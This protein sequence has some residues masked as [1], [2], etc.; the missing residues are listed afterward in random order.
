MDVTR[1]FD[2]TPSRVVVA[3]FYSNSCDNV[4]TL[5]RRLLIQAGGLTSDITH[6]PY[7][8]TDTVSETGIEPSCVRIGQNLFSVDQ[9]TST[10]MVIT[11]P[12]F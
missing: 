2:I 9:K 12:T 8:S 4:T 5:I 10:V 6:Y 7:K 3:L 1:A 11:F